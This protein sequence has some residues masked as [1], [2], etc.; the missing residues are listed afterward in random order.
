MREAR[1]LVRIARVTLKVT[2]LMGAFG[3]LRVYVTH[4]FALL[5]SRFGVHRKYP[6]VSIKMRDLGHHLLIRPGTSDLLVFHQIFVGREYEPLD[7]MVSPRLVVDAGANVGYSS[8]WF[9]SRFPTARVIALEPDPENVEVC[10]RNLEP[11]RDRVQVLTRAVWPRPGRLTILHY[12]KL[13]DR[14]ECGVQVMEGP[15]NHGALPEHVHR[16]PNPPVP[17]GEVEAIDMASVI[18]MAGSPVDLLKMDIEQAE[19]PV[20]EDGDLTWLREVSNIAIEL[21]GP[22]AREVFFGALKGF[23][24][25]SGESGELT[26]CRNIRALTHN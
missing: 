4:A 2:T 1:S 17:V 5:L 13:G 22:Q 26:I 23:S 21:H 8:A 24:Y 7:G 9:L 25:E 6:P 3:A 15:L 20:F 16:G 18:A 14:G 11:Y 19:R 12:G 10:R